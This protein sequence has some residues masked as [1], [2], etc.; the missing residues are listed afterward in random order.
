MNPTTIQPTPPRAEWISLAEKLAE[1][2]LRNLAARTLRLNMPVE[3]AAGAQREDFCHLEAFGRLLSGIAPWLEQDRPAAWLELAHE[4]I[5]AA[6]EPTSPDFLN[7][8]YQ[9]Q[10]LVDSAYLALAFLRAPQSLW[11]PLSDRVKRNVIAALKSSRVITPH[12]SNWL[13]FAATVEAALF[14]LGEEIVRS[15][16]GLAFQKH[17]EWYLGDGIYGDGPKYRADY[18][19]A[20]VIHPLLVAVSQV[21]KNDQEWSEL[22]TI[23]LERAQRYAALQERMID[24]SGCYPIMGR[25]AT[26]RFGALQ[27]LALMALR[28]ELP[29]GVSPAQVRCALTA[30][31]RRQMG[32]TGTFDEQGWLQIG[33]CG[34]QPSLGEKYINTGSL[35][36]CSNGLLPLGLPASDPFWADPDELWTA[37]MAW[38]GMDIPADYALHATR[39]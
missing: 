10:P 29:Q 21:F 13:L 17:Q 14:N 24:P 35:Y 7:F 19:N 25:S 2:V 30:V 38:S 26:Y 36:I 23:I 32:A 4:A 12:E 18:Y 37:Q 20:F 22:P 28:R 33:F 31:I 8:N 39:L 27:T 5:D 16:V 1:P 34:H 11:V 9:K 3:Q 6:T 15:R